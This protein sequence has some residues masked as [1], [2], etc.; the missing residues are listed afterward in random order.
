MSNPFQNVYDVKRVAETDNKPCFVCHKFTTLYLVT[1]CTKD[2]FPACPGHL[3]DKGFAS[4]ISPPPVP[5]P[6]PEDLEK[7]R[8][9]ALDKEIERVRKEW[10]DKQKRKQEKEKEKEKEK[11]KDEDTKKKEKE[12]KEKED[13]E[14]KE[15]EDKEKKE[16]EEEAAAKKE[17]PKQYA[18]HR[19]LYN[20]R[21]SRLR[22]IQAAKRTREILKTPGAFPAVPK[23]PIGG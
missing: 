18:L 5:V 17:P 20:M 8:K 19:D 10:E 21:L 9:E 7:R 13:K 14:K 22:Q 1:P 23:G 15:K 2:F 16:K 4:P 11:G 12:K 3:T 6:T